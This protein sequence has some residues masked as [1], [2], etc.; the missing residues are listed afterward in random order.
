[1]T[2][3]DRDPDWR[4]GFIL[5]GIGLAFWLL[6]NLLSALWLRAR[7]NAEDYDEP[8]AIFTLDEQ[9]ELVSWVNEDRKLPGVDFVFWEDEMGRP[10]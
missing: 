5:A 4:L 1:V 8:S 10:A 2:F 3:I 7:H 9:A 6:S